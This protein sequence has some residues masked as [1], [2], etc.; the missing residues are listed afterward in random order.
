MLGNTLSK[1]DL[2]TIRDNPTSHHVL[3]QVTI[4]AL[5]CFDI[6]YN[7]NSKISNLEK[8]LAE[9]TETWLDPVT[10]TTWSPPTAWAYAQACRVN[11]ERYDIVQKITSDLTGDEIA[12]LYNHDLDDGWIGHDVDE[13]ALIKIFKRIFDL[14]KKKLNIIC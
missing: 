3:V 8:Q 14:R 2:E 11:N 4:K 12:E 10:G 9:A 7:K 6:I 13:K 5:S 1:K